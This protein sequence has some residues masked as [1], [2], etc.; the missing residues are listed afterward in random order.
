MG[1]GCSAAAAPSFDCTR[2]TYP[3]EVAICSSDELAMLDNVAN[4]GYHFLRRVY[5]P[6]RANSLTLPFLHARRL[7]GDDRQCIKAEQLREIR[8]FQSFGAPQ[9]ALPDMPAQHTVHAPAPSSLD[10]A[11]QSQL[12]STTDAS[13]KK[14]LHAGR[15]VEPVDVQAPGT[16]KSDASQS[17]LVD[18]RISA[19]LKLIIGLVVCGGLY[20][21][22]VIRPRAK[23]AEQRNKATAEASEWMRSFLSQGKQM[24][25]ICGSIPNLSMETNEEVAGVLPGTTL[26]ET[27]AVRTS[28]GAYG[29]SSFRIAKGVSFRLGGYRGT[30]ESH[31][32]FREIDTGTLVL[33]SQ[34]L[35]FIGMKRTLATPL[36]KI[37]DIEETIATASRCIATERNA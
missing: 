30:S 19:L 10:K 35:I 11:D 21:L 1:L 27:R 26:M 24:K 15:T 18:Y 4:D 29:G 33:T 6:Q 36:E 31:D 9:V 28:R 37:I 23:A 16:G 2:S 22:F 5:G 14:E 34:R 12:T 17:D 32:E 8:Y 13:Q 20:F 25:F 3:D 7:C